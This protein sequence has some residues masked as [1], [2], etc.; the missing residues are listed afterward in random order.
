LFYP[1]PKREARWTLN[2]PIAGEPAVSFEGVYLSN[3]GTSLLWDAEAAFPSGCMTAVLGPSGSGKT[4]AFLAALGQHP[5]EGVIRIHG[6]DIH[7]MKKKELY[8]EVGIVFQ[9]PA[10]QFITQN[11][12]EEVRASIRVWDKGLSDAECSARAEEE[13]AG[14]GLL[15]YRRYSPYMLSQGQQR[16]L[17]VLS[18]L[19]GGQSVLFLDEPTYGQDCRS[20]ASIMTTLRKK[21]D[22][23]NLS[24]IFI[25]HDRELADAWAD[26]IY[27]LEDQRLVETRGV[28]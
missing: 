18:V 15:P 16:K 20:T 10:N 7:K 28:S 26:R 9:N 4:T 21:V 14:F 2:R 11:V 19:A 13:L 23:E 22:A 5:Y 24:V 3:E 6:T 25:T 27:C 1:D 17:A 8:K 12:E